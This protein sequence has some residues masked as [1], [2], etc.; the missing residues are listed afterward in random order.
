[1]TLVKFEIV[2]DNLRSEKVSV[3]IERSVSKGLLRVNDASI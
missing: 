2:H 3:V 1:M